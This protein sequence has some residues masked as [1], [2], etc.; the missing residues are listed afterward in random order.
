V[1]PLGLCYFNPL[2]RE[3]KRR[4]GSYYLPMAIEE[5]YDPSSSA[6]Y[7]FVLWILMYLLKNPLLR[8]LVLKDIKLTP[9]AEWV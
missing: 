4:F 7:A 8:D 9:L 6:T 3:L 5:L 2:K 1:E